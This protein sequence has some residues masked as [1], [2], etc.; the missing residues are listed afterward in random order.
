MIILS[1]VS[2]S[3]DLLLYNELRKSWRLNRRIYITL[4]VG[5]NQH[6]IEACG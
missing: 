4:I 3:N 2:E 1:R 5:E 6:I